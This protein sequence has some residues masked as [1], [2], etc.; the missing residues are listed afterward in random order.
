MARPLIH[1][2]SQAKIVAAREKRARYYAKDIILKRRRELRSSRS[3]EACAE[4]T[5]SKEICKALAK[6]LRVSDTDSESDDESDDSSDENENKLYDL[7]ECLLVIKNIKD[8]MLKMIG[9]DPCAFA[10]GILQVYVQSLTV[11]DCSTSG[12]ISIIESAMAKVQ[13]PL[14]DT[15]HAQDQILNFCGISPEWHAADSVV[16]FLKTVL[17]YLEDLLCLAVYEGVCGLTEAHALGELM[18]QKGVRI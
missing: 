18:Y 15:I 12:D 14:D 16:R 6:A 4:A 1:K 5:Q 13:K 7:P 9:N 2:T 10:Q 11:D 17:A 3:K 8:D